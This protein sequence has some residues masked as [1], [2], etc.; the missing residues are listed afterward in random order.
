MFAR[1]IAQH[2]T[3]PNNNLYS[4]GI[5]E[6]GI[7]PHGPKMLPLWNGPKMLPLQA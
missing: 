7:S 3:K 1:F 2:G 5:E 6:K 4:N